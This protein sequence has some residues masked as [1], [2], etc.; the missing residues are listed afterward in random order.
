MMF[1]ENKFNGEF[2]DKKVLILWLLERELLHN[3]S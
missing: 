3:T 2:T 1:L